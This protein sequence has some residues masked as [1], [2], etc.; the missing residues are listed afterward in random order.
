MTPTTDH[1]HIDW[2]K[3]HHT[4]GSAV[5]VPKWLANLNTPVGMTD[6]MAFAYLEGATDPDEGLHDVSA[7]IIPSLVDI[8]A[9]PHHRLIADATELAANFL[10]HSIPSRPHDDPQQQ[11]YAEAVYAELLPA[12]PHFIA[13]CR[14]EDTR[15]RLHAYYAIC[16]LDTRLDP[17]IVPSLIRTLEREGDPDL[18]AV[19]VRGIMQRYGRWRP[20]PAEREAVQ[21]TLL[22]LCDP[23]RPDDVRISAAMTL[24]LLEGHVAPAIARQTL[25]ATVA[26]ADVQPQHSPFALLLAL[27]GRLPEPLPLTLMSAIVEQAVSPITRGWVAY[28]LS[29]ALHPDDPLPAPAIHALAGLLG[30]SGQVTPNGSKDILDILFAVDPTT[31]EAALWAFDPRTLLRLDLEYYNLNAIARAFLDWVLWG[32]YD[33]DSFPQE[34]IT[35]DEL[36]EL[37]WLP[38]PTAHLDR[39]IE[40]DEDDDLDNELA[41][42]PPERRASLVTR[43]TRY[44]PAPTPLD[45]RSLSDEQRRALL[46]V[47]D[48]DGFW[49]QATNLLARYGLPVQRE[50]ARAVLMPS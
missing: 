46:K 38:P 12:V 31:A 20:A 33:E 9:K 30:L 35:A 27:M 15:V 40:A 43:A 45:V 11:A 32:V 24:L 16:E 42:I 39:Y 37:E 8:L 21:P 2:A 7:L 29:E 14:H 26:A 49:H 3:L 48:E 13:L 50:A 10:H 5:D 28:A 34:P 17:T 47:I 22:A 18:L 23:T 25:V 19:L 41:S 36:A 6:Y 4:L 44:T 1:A